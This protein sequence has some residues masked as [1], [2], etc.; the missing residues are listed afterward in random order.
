MP[1]GAV[2][3]QYCGTHCLST[4]DLKA[5]LLS[6][7]LLQPDFS[8]EDKQQDE[9]TRFA[10]EKVVH[11]EGF[12][13]YSR[14]EE[15]IN[16]TSQELGHEFVP[17][18][19]REPKLKIVSTTRDG[20]QT[21][22]RIFSGS[23]SVMDAEQGWE[24]TSKAMEITVKGRLEAG[25]TANF[26]HGLSSGFRTGLMHNVVPVIT[27]DLEMQTGPMSDSETNY[28]STVFIPQRIPNICLSSNQ[29]PLSGTYIVPNDSET[30][31]SSDAPKNLCSPGVFPETNNSLSSE[32]C[33]LSSNG[34]LETTSV[35]SVSDK[36]H[37]LN[38]N[39]NCQVS[40]GR[41]HEQQFASSDLVHISNDNHLR[42]GSSP[43]LVEEVCLYESNSNSVS[44][45]TATHD[46]H[47]QSNEQIVENV[48]LMTDPPSSDC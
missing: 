19:E 36:T 46:C 27:S 38:T 44:V 25:V 34:L 4:D 6:H 7:T 26:K 10:A 21:Q 40:V 5:H 20:L 8:Q 18:G 1:R 43:A 42:L 23:N 48:V 41:N 14:A 31:A 3:C 30:S 17:H 37:T 12:H 22:E 2:K 39:E 15:V 35:A 45:P 28:H 11:N 9:H 24:A 29:Q 16:N 13:T 33:R 32:V 47:V